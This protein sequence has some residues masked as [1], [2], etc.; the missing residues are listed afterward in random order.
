MVETH[1]N[2]LTKMLDLTGKYIKLVLVLVA[3]EKVGISDKD[4]WIKEYF[5]GKVLAQMPYDQF[6]D[7]KLQT[8]ALLVKLSG[9]DSL[10]NNKKIQEIKESINKFHYRFSRKIYENNEDLIKIKREIK[11]NPQKYAGCMETDIIK[12]E[13]KTA[14][15]YKSI[16][17]IFGPP[18]NRHETFDFVSD[19]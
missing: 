11:L 2:D 15:I 5:M 18:L 19:R 1:N 13:T 9:E 16:D 17:V 3:Q 14:G 6:T 4:K 12:I 10:R 8:L 7:F